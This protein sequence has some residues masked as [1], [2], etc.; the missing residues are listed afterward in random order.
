MFG[1]FW[2]RWIARTAQGANATTDYV[3]LPVL[4]VASALLGNARWVMAWGGWKGPPALWCGSVG[5]P[6]S[7]KS[8]GASP[9]TRDV[10]RKVE[11]HM[12]RGYPAELVR[13]EEAAAVAKTALKAW[14][15]A[16]AQA[17]K[18][19]EPPPPKPALAQV[20]PKPIRPRASMTDATVEAVAPLLAGLP[21]GVLNLRDEMAGW[22]LNLARYSNGGTDRPFWLEAYNGGPYQVDRQK[23][24]VP[25]YVPHL[26]VPAFGTIQPERLSDLLN[27]TDDGL[28]SR[29]LWAWPE[30]AHVFAK[31]GDTGDP[32]QAAGALRRLADLTM[33]QA[34]DGTPIPSYV[35]LEDGAEQV[36]VAFARKAQ[37]M[38]QGAHG[39]LKSTLGK[40]RGQ[41]LRLSGV[42]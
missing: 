23:Y 41:A 19:G 25:I 14:E 39:L 10:L 11:A 29:F 6:S 40:A 31:P 21:K 2:S 38:E 13:R 36:L 17:I 30:T 4:A 34:E 42:L 22:L 32:D 35:P 24:P 26:T 33:A 16:V 37:T 18:D 1:P 5:N 20:P 9:V 27:G 15:R 7:G 28:A 3:E 8:S 12:A